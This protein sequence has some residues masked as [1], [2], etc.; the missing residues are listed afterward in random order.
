MSNPSGAQYV[1]IVSRGGPCPCR[2]VTIDAA[3]ATVAHDVALA[4][5]PLDRMHGETAVGTALSD[6]ADVAAVTFEEDPASVSASH[7]SGLVIYSVLTGQPLQSFENPTLGLGERTTSTPAFQPGSDSVALAA[8]D[9]STNALGGVLMDARSGAVLHTFSMPVRVGR[10]R[11]RRPERRR[12]RAPVQSR[13]PAARGEH[14][15]Q[16]GDLER[17]IRGLERERRVQ[18]GA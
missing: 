8:T 7:R 2:I 12:V 6:A 14:R 1:A 13:R 18:R 5:S 11:Q 15:R 4:A 9:A 10:G 16:R 17:R 3:T